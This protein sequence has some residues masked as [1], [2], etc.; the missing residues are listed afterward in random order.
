ME[1]DFAQK[2]IMGGN[3]SYNRPYTRK[4]GTQGKAGM[5]FNNGTTKFPVRMTK[6]QI[7]AIWRLKKDE[8]F[9]NEVYPN[10]E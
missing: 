2:P 4:D 6:E 10:L 8:D 3:V 5:S 7:E 9:M 1:R